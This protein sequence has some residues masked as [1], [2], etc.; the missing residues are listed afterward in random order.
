M[1]HLIAIVVLPFLM[2]AC[3]TPEQRAAR[4]QQQLTRLGE[5]CEKIGYEPGTDRHKDCVLQL[6]AAEDAPKP[7]NYRPTSSRCTT[8]NGQMTCTSY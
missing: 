8:F 4:E 6:L 7:S 3:A 5:K 1:R 2:A